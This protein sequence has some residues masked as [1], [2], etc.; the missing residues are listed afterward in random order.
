[1]MEGM[2]S[3]YPEKLSLPHTPSDKLTHPTCPK[4]A[5][6]ATYQSSNFHVMKEIQNHTPA[7]VQG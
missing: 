1:M 2:K 3:E 6:N 5:D 7:L 4:W